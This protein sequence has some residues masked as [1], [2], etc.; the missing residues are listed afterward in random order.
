[1][2]DVNLTLDLRM[3]VNETTRH[4]VRR[5]GFGDGYEVV[6]KDGINTRQTEY[7]ITTEPIKDASTQTSFISDLDKVA[8][9][10]YFLATLAPFSSVA[11]RYRLKDNTYS[12]QILPSNRAMTFSFTLVEAFANA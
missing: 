3:E 5:Y 7:S 6:A 1:M 2:A 9:G 11:R 12:R 4:R 10:D 8:T